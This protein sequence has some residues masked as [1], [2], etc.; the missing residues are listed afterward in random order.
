MEPFRSKTAVVKTYSIPNVGFPSLDSPHSTSSRVVAG[1]VAGEARRRSPTCIH[2]AGTKYCGALSLETDQVRPD[3]RIKYLLGIE[4]RQVY[5][6][7]HKLL[8]KLTQ[9]SKQFCSLVP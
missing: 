7:Q 3:A 9:C 8:F 4:V 1:W 5:P 6:L 2:R